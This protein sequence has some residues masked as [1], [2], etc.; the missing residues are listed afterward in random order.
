MLYFCKKKVFGISYIDSSQRIGINACP[1]HRIN[2]LKS[3]TT[4]CWKSCYTVLSL[5]SL[6][7]KIM[8]SYENY[9]INNVG[10]VLHFIRFTF[11]WKHILFKHINLSSASQLLYQI[12]QYFHSTSVPHGGTWYDGNESLSASRVIS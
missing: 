4:F 12:M 11:V 10:Y 5:S 9:V 2:F 7:N 6:E 3:K 8:L 1:L